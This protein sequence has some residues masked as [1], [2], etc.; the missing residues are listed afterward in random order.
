MMFLEL[1]S[2]YHRQKSWKPSGH[3]WGSKATKDMQ[4]AVELRLG[5][6]KEGPSLSSS[7]PPYF[8]PV[9]LNGQITAGCQ[10]SRNLV[11]T[12]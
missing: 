7:F 3:V 1:S 11:N 2:W 12:A 5:T 8:L 4:Q 9:P 6:G 10:L